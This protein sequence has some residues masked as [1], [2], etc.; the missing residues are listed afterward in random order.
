MSLEADNM[1]GSGRR[2][3]RR[4]DN[5]SRRRRG[6]SSRAKEAKIPLY[7]IGFGREVRRRHHAENGRIHRRPFLP[8]HQYRQVDRDIRPSRPIWHDDGI[9]EES[10]REIASKTGGQYFPVKNASELKIIL[11]QVTQSIQQE[12]HVVFK[13]LNQR[14]DGTRRSVTLRLTDAKDVTQDQQSG[15][16]FRRGLVVAEMNHV[17]YLVLLLGIAGLI[18]LPGLLRRSAAA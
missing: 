4:L 13:S 12:P 3:D 9:D 5:T 16:Y 17:V 14:A 7:L 10:L 18:A 15:G 2:Y 1:P 11:E 6:R 8:C